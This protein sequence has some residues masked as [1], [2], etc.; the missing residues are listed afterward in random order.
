MNISKEKNKETCKITVPCHF[1][2]SFET[3]LFSVMVPGGD[4]GSQI[5]RISNL[6]GILEFSSP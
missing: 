5:L 6:D 1:H 4:L 3:F 2:K